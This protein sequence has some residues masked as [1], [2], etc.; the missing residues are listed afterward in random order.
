MQRDLFE[1]PPAPPPEWTRLPGF[2]PRNTCG[3]IWVHRSGWKVRHC[4]H[5][6]ALWPWYGVPPGADE[7]DRSQLLLK[8]GVGLDLRAT[9]LAP[10]DQRTRAAAALPSVIWRARV[11]ISS[12]CQKH[13][14]G[15]RLL[16]SAF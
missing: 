1:L 6:T 10:D 9:T 4:G 5:P 11:L 8:G 13:E 2:S 7:G 15:G 12:A 16:P 14:R 3:V